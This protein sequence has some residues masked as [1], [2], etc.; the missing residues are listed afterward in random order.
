MIILAFFSIILFKSE[1]KRNLT[2]CAFQAFIF[3]FQLRF[4]PEYI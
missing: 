3:E 2:E 1:D 4:N